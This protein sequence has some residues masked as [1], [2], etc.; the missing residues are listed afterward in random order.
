MRIRRYTGKDIQEAMLKVK[1]DLGSDAVILSTRKVRKKGIKGLFSKPMTE[2]LAAVDDD[3]I[4]RRRSPEP[5]KIKSA[6]S[7]DKTRIDLLENRLN[8][9]E[10]MIKNM[11]DAQKNEALSVSER[12]LKYENPKIETSRISAINRLNARPYENPYMLFTKKLSESEV[13]PEV[14]NALVNN[15]RHSVGDSDSYE[16]IMA[17]A[18]KRLRKCWASHRLSVCVTTANRQWYCLWGLQVSAKQPLLLN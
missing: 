18:E 7:E 9:I 14:I 16:E 1:M 10:T 15:I 2:I 4:S 8:R 6:V 5:E 13:E 17:V 3:I 12:V 11:Y